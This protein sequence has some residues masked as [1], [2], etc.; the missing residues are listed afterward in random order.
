[1]PTTI[2]E[3]DAYPN[4]LQF[5]NGGELASAPGLLS[6]FGQGVA[7]RL[8]W[9]KNRI[10]PYRLV[11]G[12]DAN[13]A[14]NPTAGN[15]NFADV[16]A[17]S[18]NRVWTLDDTGCVGGDWFGVRN[19]SAFSIT[20]KDPGGTD[21]AVLSANSL[22]FVL[23]V[24]DNSAW[25]VVQAEL[26]SQSLKRSNGEFTGSLKVGSF[27]DVVGS[28]T[29][30][31]AG[32]ASLKFPA[33]SLPDANATISRRTFTNFV[34]SNAPAFTATIFGLGDGDNEWA[35]VH[36]LNPNGCTVKD[37]SGNTLQILG[38]GGNPLTSMIAM[39]IAGVWTVVFTG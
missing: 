12:Y 33:E 28:I 24:R 8:N 35:A 21:L 6:L 1:M 2:S 19:R 39:R 17:L 16:L 31:G 15:A 22:D 7:N 14:P 26:A 25:R 36:S 23:V 9:L 27:L 38:L 4:A 18:A 30:T 34:N 37:P 13:I 32:L 3:S 5:P 10:R 11:S 29:N 20:L